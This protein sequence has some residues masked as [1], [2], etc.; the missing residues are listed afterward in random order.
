MTGLLKA[1]II[2]SIVLVIACLIR[3]IRG[4]WYVTISLSIFLI[5][6]YYLVLNIA[7]LKRK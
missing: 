3:E 2:G 4:P 6:T 7:G 1:F 5:L